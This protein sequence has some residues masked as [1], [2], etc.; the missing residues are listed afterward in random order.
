MVVSGDR[1]A[2]EQATALGAEAF[3]PKPLQLATVPTGEPSR[4]LESEPVAVI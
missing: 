1:D 3:L 2:D 4:L